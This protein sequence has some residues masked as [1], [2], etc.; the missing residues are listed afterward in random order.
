MLA[1]LGVVDKIDKLIQQIEWLNRYL[2]QR[3]EMFVK[4][5]NHYYFRKWGPYTGM[6]LEN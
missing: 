4:R 2:S 5:L 3:N 6:R 1:R